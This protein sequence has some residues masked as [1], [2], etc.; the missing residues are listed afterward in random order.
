M[1]VY[2]YPHVTS[3]G[4]FDKGFLPYLRSLILTF[5]KT[6][7]ILGGYLST[8]FDGTATREELLSNIEQ[9]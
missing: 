6:I 2:H 1:R 7:N 5:H 3:S 9:F 8:H 4:A